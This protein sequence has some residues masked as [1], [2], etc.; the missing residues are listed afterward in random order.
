MTFYRIQMGKKGTKWA[1]MMVNTRNDKPI[2]G[3]LMGSVYLAE[4]CT[5][6]CVLNIKL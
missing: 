4:Q 6:A 2:P 5:T 1:W 3:S